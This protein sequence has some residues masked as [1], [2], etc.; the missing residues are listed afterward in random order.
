MPRTDNSL[1]QLDAA[2]SGLSDP[3]HKAAE[4]VSF[5]TRLG[6]A[7]P[8]ATRAPRATGGNTAGAPSLPGLPFD[9]HEL[10]RLVMRHGISPSLY[11]TALNRQD[12]RPEVLLDEVPCAFVNPATRDE[13]LK[14]GS[15][16]CGGCRLVKYCS[17][18]RLARS[19]QI[20]VLL[21]NV[22]EVPKE[23]LAGRSLRGVFATRNQ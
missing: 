21:T 12:D 13:C 8:P 17:K 10:N 3:N 18:V 20:L 9:E 23:A 11:C 19:S 7:D 22:Q 5:L 4:L 16:V 6:I 2:L 1:R 14:A 15:R